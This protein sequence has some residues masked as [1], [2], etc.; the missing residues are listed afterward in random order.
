MWEMCSMIYSVCS[1]DALI[2]PNMQRTVNVLGTPIQTALTNCGQGSAAC[3]AAWCARWMTSSSRRNEG[4]GHDY[5]RNTIGNP[6]GN[7]GLAKWK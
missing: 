5:L 6:N 7:D 2:G 3:F 4:P 1:K